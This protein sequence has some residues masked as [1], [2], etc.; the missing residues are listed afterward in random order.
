MN[1]KLNKVEAMDYLSSSKIIEIK[2]K[3]DLY[4]DSNFH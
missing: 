2:K 3:I 1:G 4:G